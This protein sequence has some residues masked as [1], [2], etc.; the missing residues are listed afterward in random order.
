MITQLNHNAFNLI[1]QIE[2][3][4]LSTYNWISGRKEA[5][6]SI[7]LS[8]WIGHS[9]VSRVQGAT[10]TYERMFVNCMHYELDNRILC[11]PCG[12]SVPTL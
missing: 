12:Y 2:L 11:K 7:I 10:D 3:T 6:E 8:D 9:H 1:L 5:K 4:L